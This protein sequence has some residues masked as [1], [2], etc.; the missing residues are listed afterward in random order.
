M[1]RYS[2]KQQLEQDIRTE[3]DLLCAVLDQIPE[4][5]HDE[6]GVWGDGWT[7]KD[8]VAHLAEWQLMF[9]GWYD[10][11][12]KGAIPELPAPGY[13]WNETPR[14]NRGIW[15]KHRTR[16]L[17]SV[18]SDFDSGYR[19][20]LEIVQGLSGEQLLLPGYFDWTG[21]HGLTTYLGANTA[22]HYRFAMKVIKRWL[23]GRFHGRE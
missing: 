11:G 12:V 14:L 23:A 19:R 13:K 8:L 1:M 2:S 21:S 3:H 20:I 5:R 16:S 7:V 6:Q 15:L 17:S 4:A 10:A 18:R 9:L 22:S